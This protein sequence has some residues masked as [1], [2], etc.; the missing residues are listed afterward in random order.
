MSSVSPMFLMEV[1][2]KIPERR[3]IWPIS[4][5]LCGTATTHPITNIGVSRRGGRIW[6][7]W[8]HSHCSLQGSA[9]TS[10]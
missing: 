6:L 4:G 2:T 7:A 10:E 9:S 1:G 5:R 8:P 3:G